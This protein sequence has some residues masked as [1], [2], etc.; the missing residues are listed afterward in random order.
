MRVSMKS[1]T[2]LKLNYVGSKTRS[3][4]QIIGNPYQHIRDHIFGPIFMKLGQ[5]V[6]IDEIWDEF[7]SMLG[8]LKN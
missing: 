7:E 8:Q 5:I 2:S 6:C 1:R 3:L 4:G